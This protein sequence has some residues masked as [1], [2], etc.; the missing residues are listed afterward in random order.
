MV[1]AAIGLYW[2]RTNGYRCPGQ[3]FRISWN[4]NGLECLVACF[5]GVLRVSR[6]LCGTGTS[7][8]SPVLC[9]PVE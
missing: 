5:E 8:K 9:T 1:L 6:L 4:Y 2:P 3:L 7:R